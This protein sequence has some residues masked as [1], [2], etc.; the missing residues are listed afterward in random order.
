MALELKRD[1]MIESPYREGGMHPDLRAMDE[2]MEQLIRFRDEGAMNDSDWQQSI[3]NILDFQREDGS[4]SFLSDYRIPSDARVQYLYRP[5]YACCQVLMRFLLND[6]AVK[7]EGVARVKEALDRG[8]AFC[9]TRKLAGHGYDSLAEQMEDAILFAECGAQ[10]IRYVYPDIAPQFFQ[11]LDEIGEGYARRIRNCQVFGD[12]GENLALPL[13]RAAEALGFEQKVLVFVYGTLMTGMPNEHYLTH[14]PYVG[15]AKVRDYALYD[16]GAF[17]G[18]KPSDVNSRECEV[19]GEIRM[20][21]ASTREALNRLEGE[22]SLYRLTKVTAMVN[23]FPLPVLTYVYCHDVDADS[24]IPCALQPYNRYLQQRGDLVW[25]V[26]YGQ[27]MLF[28]HF[29]T[30]LRGGRCDVSGFES[31]GCT[32]K[33]APLM[34]SR[35]RLDY[36]LHVGE[37]NRPFLRLDKEGCTFARAYLVTRGQYNQVRSI[38]GVGEGDYCDEVELGMW[39]GIPLLAVTNESSYQPVRIDFGEDVDTSD[40]DEEDLYEEPYGYLGMEYYDAFFAGLRE[41]WFLIPEKQL[42]AYADGL[43]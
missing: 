1:L 9:C 37:C 5:S 21:D 35:I 20:V 7:G 42:E 29:M 43:C 13:L 4:F 18:I 10:A 41:T 11:L 19:Q 16:L 15:E 27:D 8:L 36:G 2:Q 33:S 3:R 31:E 26:A 40:W 28:E 30:I 25:Y 22:G 17:P 6:G 23:G 32:D 24:E 14:A 38:M 34:S 12:W 39:G